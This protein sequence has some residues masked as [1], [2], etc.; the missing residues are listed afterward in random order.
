MNSP[1][2]PHDPHLRTH[3]LDP[4]HRRINGRQQLLLITF[5]ALGTRQDLAE[6]A[7]EAV[8]L[9]RHR[10]QQGID[11]RFETEIDLGWTWDLRILLG[12]LGGIIV[13]WDFLGEGLFKS[14]WGIWH[15]GIFG[16]MKLDS[17][18]KC[19]ISP[20][21]MKGKQVWK[22]VVTRSNSEKNKTKSWG[23]KFG[24]LWPCAKKKTCSYGWDP[25]FFS[26]ALDSTSYIVLLC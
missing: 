5:Q 17:C 16:W 15:F 20:G 24:T 21:G 6:V 25:E 7:A 2:N 12:I 26:Q 1:W 8:A 10:Q 14:I 18:K 11:G 19:I 9:P 3:L 23:S 22:H 4:L 13:W